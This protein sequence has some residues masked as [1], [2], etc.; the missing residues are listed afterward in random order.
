MIEVIAEHSVDLSLLPEKAFVLDIGCRGFQ[1]TDAMTD[2]GHIVYPVDIDK[3]HQHNRPSYRR[4]YI[5]AISGKNGTCSVKYSNDPQAT[6]IVDGPDILMYTVKSFSDFVEVKFWDLIKIDIEGSE[7]E[8]MMSLTEPP[9]KQLSIEF[10]LHTGV[11][12]DKQV[13]EMEDKLIALGYLPVKHD[14]TSQH[15]A[16]YNYWDSL[17][18]LQEQRYEYSEPTNY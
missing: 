12:G 3:L 18:I 11:Y 9:A 5:M 7:Y 17:F 16:G 1:F 10:H 15:G 2:L 8:V 13:K 4:Y 14:K 6:K